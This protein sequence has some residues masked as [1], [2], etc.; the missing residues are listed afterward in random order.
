MKCKIQSCGTAVEQRQRGW[1]TGL[2]DIAL[3]RMVV[4][5]YKARGRV[6]L[7]HSLA[8][9]TNSGAEAWVWTQVTQET[10]LQK[11][12]PKYRFLYLCWRTGLCRETRLRLSPSS[13]RGTPKSNKLI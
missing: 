12:G 5:L 8:G 7:I 11:Q 3:T 10:L 1:G 4:S 6:D 13:A 9:N 2:P